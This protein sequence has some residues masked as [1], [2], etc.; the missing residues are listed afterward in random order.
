MSWVRKILVGSGEANI[1]SEHYRQD[2]SAIPPGVVGGAEFS[3][4]IELVQ[5]T[6]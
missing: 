6:V 3:A 1:G 4:V 5:G 2:E